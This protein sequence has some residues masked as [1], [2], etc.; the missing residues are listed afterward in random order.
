MDTI[1][2]LIPLVI[3][4]DDAAMLEKFVLL[5]DVECSFSIKRPGELRNLP[6]VHTFD[7]KGN[8]QWFDEFFTTQTPDMGRIILLNPILNDMAEIL[9]HGDVTSSCTFLKLFDGAKRTGARRG[10]VALKIGVVDDVTRDSAGHALHH[11]V[12]ITCKFWFCPTPWQKSTSVA[13]SSS[14]PKTS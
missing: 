8:I 13:P 6:G 7:T 4:H 14:G 5:R 1:S 9:V 10:D 11:D 3:T 12:H 2:E